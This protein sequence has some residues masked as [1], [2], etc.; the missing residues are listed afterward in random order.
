[1]TARVLR[2]RLTKL[3]PALGGVFL[4]TSVLVSSKALEAAFGRAPGSLSWGPALFRI[5][6]AIHGLALV[7]VPFLAGKSDHPS[8]PVAPTSDRRSYAILAGIMA[9]AAILR[10]PGLNSCMWLDEVLTMVRFVR[11]GV[12]E[13]L[14]SFPDQN[15]HMLYSLLA[16]A[17]VRIFGEQVWVVRLP[18]VLFGV[19]SIWALFLLGRYLIG[20]TG[21]LLSCGLLAVSYHHIWFSQNARGYMGLLFFTILSTWLWLE[22]TDRGR[23][24][25]WLL[26]ALAIA[27]GAWIHMTML[28][29]VAAHALIFVASW[30]LGDRRVTRLA[31]AL[32]GFALAG[33]LTLQFYALALPQFLA[34]AAGEVSPPSEWTKPWWVVTE[35]LRSLQIGFAAVA[36]LAVG[37]AL[38]AAGSIDLLRRHARAFFAMVLPALMGGAAM[39]TL[40]HNLWPRFFFFSMAFGVLLAVDGALVLARLLTFAPAFPMKWANAAGLGLA[41]LMILASASTV[42]R[43]YAPKQNFTGARAYVE[44]ELS[45]GDAVVVAGL[46]E[47]AY[48]LYYAPSWKTVR[49]ARELA[50]TEAQA[51]HTFVVYTLPIELRAAEPELWNAIQSGFETERIF[52]GTLGGGEVYVC[53]ERDGTPRAR[54]EA[55]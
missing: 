26:Y 13:I 47:H 9:V 43:A 22:A 1:M 2:P 15:Q 34:S 45:S 8:Q 25:E 40:G 12:K 20:E 41:G 19:A 53:R 14:T 36:V 49:T 30:F 4:L 28:F 52:W 17:A 7:S 39:L 11:P 6:L 5:L 37:G 51:H 29:V 38:V 27:L 3:C 10:I 33:T 42:P 21:A 54:A 44:Q 48:S 46:A 24:R 32:A 31:K 50:Q 35:A 23:W 16:H 55:N 18:S